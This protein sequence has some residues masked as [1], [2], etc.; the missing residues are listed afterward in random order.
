MSGQGEVSRARLLA[1][2]AEACEL[3]HALCCSYLYA[4][5]SLKRDIGEGLNWRQQQ[6][7]RRWASRIYHIAAQEMLHLAQ[8]WNIMTACGGAPYYRRPHFPQPA[9]HFPLNVALTLRRFDSATLDRFIVYERPEDMPLT[10]A[11][12]PSA[13]LWPI[14]EDFIY[15]S[16]GELY[17]EIERILIECDDPALFVGDGALQADQALIDF[18]DILAVTDRESAIAAIHR[19]TEQGEGTQWDREDSHFGVFRHIRAQLD[20]LDF[21]PA[22]PVA[23]NPYVTRSMRQ[24]LV[25]TS[26]AFS[27]AGPVVTPILTAA[28]SHA[29]DLFNDV[30]VAMLQALAHIFSSSSGSAGA[31]RQIARDALELMITVIKPLG[32]AICRLPSGRDGLNAGPSFEMARHVALP[33]DSRL[34]GAVFEDRLGQLRGRGQRLLQQ[35]MPPGPRTQIAGAVA[36]IGRM[37]DQWSRRKR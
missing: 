30:Y 27:G 34:A 29:I 15:D 26:G 31:R 13:E 2:L 12:V 28:A 17:G 23:D 20:G 21:T 32:E 16:V 37:V 7:T 33:Q 14:D 5:F 6:I 11:A 19:I 10:E 9:K 1:L 22:F 25:E 36:N 24:I 18:Y 4:A 3:E 35:D 8:A